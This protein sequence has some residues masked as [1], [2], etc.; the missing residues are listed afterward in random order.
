[1]KPK[2]IHS[3]KINL[4]DEE[5]KYLTIGANLKKMDV[6]EYIIYL[7]EKDAYN[8]KWHFDELNK[9]NLTALKIFNKNV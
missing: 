4:T 7:I 6:R 2:K 5:N 3:Y 8:L 1:M 9:T